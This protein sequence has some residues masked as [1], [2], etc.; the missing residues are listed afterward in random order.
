[1]SVWKYVK[2]DG[3]WRYKAAIEDK[4]KIVPNMVRVSGQVEFHEEGTYYFRSGRRWVR[5]DAMPASTQEARERLL[6]WIMHH[7]VLCRP[8]SRR[9][10]HVAPVRLHSAIDE[11]DRRIS[12]DLNSELENLIA[13]SADG[14][15]AGAG[16][17][18]HVAEFLM[19]QRGVN[20]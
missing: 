11:T 14:E 9:I 7:G 16:V 19:S 2:V 15:R 4:G 6:D 18:G 8:H 10:R 5:L 3:V 12:S 20:G 1:M 13:R 17:L